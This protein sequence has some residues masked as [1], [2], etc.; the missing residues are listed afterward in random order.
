[1][2]ELQRTDTWNTNPVALAEMISSRPCECPDWCGEVVHPLS[3]GTAAEDVC[4]EHIN[5]FDVGIYRIALT[6][7]QYLFDGFTDQ[8]ITIYCGDQT[9]LE[10]SVNEMAE[11]ADAIAGSVPVGGG[12][13][14]TG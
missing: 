10:G 2:A 7:S 8:R 1:M 11:L 3:M 12:G 5:S 14:T 4:Y 6:E 13:G 9:L